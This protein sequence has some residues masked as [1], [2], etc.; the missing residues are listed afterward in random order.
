MKKVLGVVIL[1]VVIFLGIRQCRSGGPEARYQAF[2]EEVLH[3]RYAEAAGMAEGLTEADLRKVGTQERI[4][5][6]ALFQTLF[7]SRFKIESQDRAADGTVTLHATQTVLFNP[8]GVESALRPAMFATMKQ[9]VSLR[10][11][12]GGWKVTKFENEF[13]RM[14]SLT[15]R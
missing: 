4:G 10:K 12:R 7:P 9:S 6:P 13:E 1:A 11:L 14:D 3:R 15:D 5:G 2:A 8:V